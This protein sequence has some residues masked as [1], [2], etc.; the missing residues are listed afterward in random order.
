MKDFEEKI[1]LLAEKMKQA[2]AILIGA[3][4]G[5]STN[6]GLE[7]DG[8]GFRE[9]FGDY[10]GAYGFRDLY[11]SG[12]YPFRT[13]G[14]RWAYWARH[15]DFIRFRPPALPLY[16][17]LHSLVA[18]LDYFVI[19]TNVDGQFYK[20]GFAADRIFAVQGD[21]SEM[22]CARGCHPKVYDNSEAVKN[23]LANSHDFSVDEKFLPRC[24]VCGGPMDMHLR[25]DEFFVEDAA[26]HQM[27]KAYERFLDTYGNRNL[28][29]LELG[30]GFNT[31]TIIRYPFEAMAKLNHRA[32]L[33]RVNL[34]QPD[35]L[36]PLNGNFLSF[37][38]K[39]NI[40]LEALA[41]VLQEKE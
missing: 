31:P 3:G 7:Y 23:I 8:P 26:W 4:A 30:V 29:M 35:T 32:F 13:E 27:A 36:T 2:S 6:A 21:Y 34:A 24:P 40:A 25:K 12:F 15:I 5:L 9:N 39:A 38:L 33:C 14:E 28:L 16:K 11:S 19:T 22:Q 1:S 41:K 18:K 20:S 37:P 10:I 17:L